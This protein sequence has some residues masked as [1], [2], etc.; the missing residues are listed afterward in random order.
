MLAPTSG[1]S[2]PETKRLRPQHRLYLYTNFPRKIAKVLHMSCVRPR[3]TFKERGVVCVVILAGKFVCKG[4]ANY[5]HLREKKT[6]S[7]FDRG[8]TGAYGTRAK[9]TGF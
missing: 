7:R 2:Y 6:P 3:R 9:K 1:R 5:I 4:E 8:V